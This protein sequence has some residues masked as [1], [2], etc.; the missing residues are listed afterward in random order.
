[1]LLPGLAAAQQFATSVVRGRVTDS[2]GAALPGVTVTA[3]H[4]ATNTEYRAVSGPAGDYVVTAVR[5][6]QY[7]VRFELAGFSR[8]ERTGVLVEVSQEGRVDASLA[9]GAISEVVT[10]QGDASI[11]ETSN[12]TVKTVVDS[13]RIVGLPLNGRNA[14][15]LQALTPGA[16]QVK[17][18]QAATGIALMTSSSYSINGARPNG[19]GYY[20]DGG[21]NM[22]M[23]NNV[24]T[25][26]PNPDALQEFSVLA[27][28]MQA[29]YGRSAGA[30]INMVTK[31][32]TNQLHGSAYGFYRNDA[33]NGTNFFAKTKPKLD[34]KQF[35]ATVGGPIISDRTFFF[36]AYEGVRQE[37]D[38]TRTVQV[39]TALERAGDFSQSPLTGARVVIDPL[40]GLPFPGNIVPTSRFDP[41]AVAFTNAFMPLPNSTGNLYTF[42]VTSPENVDQFV[43][44][45]DHQLSANNRLSLRG[46]YD[47]T[48]RTLN[49]NLPAFNSDFSWKTKNLTL[50]DVHTFSGN[51]VNTATVTYASNPVQRRPLPSDPRTWTDLGCISCVNLGDSTG[52]NTQWG[53]S[54]TG[55]GFGTESPF[56][57]FMTN[58]HVTDSITWITGRHLFRAGGEFGHFTRQG[59]EPF[60]HT[61]QFSF[62][63]TRTKSGWGYT[64]F[65][66]GLPNN[67]SQST[68]LASETTRLNLA[69]YVEDEWKVSNRLTLDL[70]LRWEP[71]FPINETNDE[72]TAYRPG[73]QSTIYKLATPG[74]VFPGDPGIPRGIVDPQYDLFAPRV[75]VAFDPT[76]DGKTSIRAGWGLFYDT[77]RQVSLNFASTREPFALFATT[78]TS[79][80]KS[81]QDPYGNNPETLTRLVNYTSPQPGQEATWQFFGTPLFITSIDEDLTPPRYQQWNLSVQHQLFADLMVQAAYV[82]SK[83]ENLLVIQEIN[84]GTYV[85]G[86]TA[87]NLQA[88]R[89]DPTFSTIWNTQSTGHSRYDAFQLSVNKRFSRGFSVL[90]SYVYSSSKDTASNDG[91]S[92][93]SN[94][95]SNPRD[96]EA[97]WG[98]SDFDVPHRFVASFLWELPF[99]E[100]SEGLTKTLLGGWQVGGIVTLQSGTPFSAIVG[101]NQRS[102]VGGNGDRLDVIGTER[103][104]G[105]S[106]DEQVNR[107]FDTSAYA[108]P[109]LGTFGTVDRNSLRGP[110]YQ[111]VDLTVQKLFGLGGARALELRFEVFNLFNQVNFNNPVNVYCDRE[112]SASCNFGK[113]TSALDPRII[114]LGAR[115]RF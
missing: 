3:I 94:G 105:G 76:G 47:D 33:L 55:F 22:D 84:P 54:F 2:S 28:S 64:D 68:P 53:T 16:V 108:L 88:R 106:Q 96:A 97:D 32:G 34:R 83:G 100:G 109:P 21:I 80:P 58:W 112:T 29:V 59:V 69:A 45:I 23:Y 52:A 66:L 24:A 82:G 12:A 4:A 42:N 102:L 85:P 6:G 110:G 95:S 60:Q 1:M 113:L 44:R 62:N 93:G 14:L 9:P 19:S 49:A 30:A 17:F 111:N 79:N 77:I 71:F 25:A 98:P 46:F 26:F 48:T 50:S 39:P 5:P 67:V 74:L 104:L 91:N 56:T 73:Q 27:N 8:T 70:G 40:T 57:S 37:S 10:V 107:Y 63:G 90:A 89:D 78:N 36:L 51:V 92:G 31:S 99:F 101:N 72:L 18:G 7:S 86:A 35:G 65:F 115:F 81:L 87:T 43:G 15:Q 61:P 11:V 20:L 38:S 13:R 103:V 75:G 41:V 114:Q